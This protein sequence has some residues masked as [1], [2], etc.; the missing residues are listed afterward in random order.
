MKY[1]KK[2]KNNLL[3]NKNKIKISRRNYNTTPNIKKMTQKGGIIGKIKHWYNMRKF[4]Y[5]L[6]KFDKTKKALKS[7]YESFAAESEFYEKD[8]K[9]KAELI[10][11]YLIAT[12]VNTIVELQRLNE[13]PYSSNPILKRSVQKDQKISKKKIKEFKKRIS[14]LDK[15]NRGNRSEFKRMN[16]KF[17]K[18]VTKFEKTMDSYTDMAGFM[19]EI[20][21]LYRKYARISSKD[22]KSLS[23]KHRKLLS[24]FKGNEEN[25]KKV[26]AF[27]ESYMN[28]TN[29]FVNKYSELRR[30]AEFYDKQ[31]NSKSISSFDSKIKDWREEIE[32]FYLALKSCNEDGKN[33]V[34][35]YETNI[36]KL[37]NIGR[38][39]R[40]V[41]DTKT[42]KVVAITI[43]LLET[44]LKHQKDIND[45]I[46]KLQINF[47][48]NQPA[49]RLQWDSNLVHAKAYYIERLLKEIEGHLV[50]LK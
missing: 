44:C 29:K 37:V 8:A 32:K 40:N 14:K 36:K 24:K 7:E 6:N 28:N 27:N 45:L 25:Y 21:T 11:Q 19:E 9:R 15:E 48:Q 1:S 39:L 12:K 13:E 42:M 3:L 10:S 4:N 47:F 38:R 41:D 30:K 43:K 46:R 31:F 22:K 20:S 26:Y 23:K 17:N 35:K 18:N 2:G 50:K 49:I 34:K 16:K 33:F 5:F